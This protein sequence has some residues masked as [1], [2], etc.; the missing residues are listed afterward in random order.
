MIC[1]RNEIIGAISLWKRLKAIRL[2]TR[3]LDSGEMAING[4]C[5]GNNIDS[6]VQRVA[7]LILSLILQLKILGRIL[8]PNEGLQ[9]MLAGRK[10]P[11]ITGNPCRGNPCVIRFVSNART[12]APWSEVV[13]CFTRGRHSRDIL[14]GI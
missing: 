9:A 4:R 1:K 11:I 10:D 2:S 13:A 14:V 5:S 6:G 3:Y 7:I 12:R 8:V